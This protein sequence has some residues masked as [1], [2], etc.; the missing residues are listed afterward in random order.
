MSLEIGGRISPKTSKSP[1]LPMFV[2]LKNG[3]LI[4]LFL[5][6]LESST[7]DI[8][9]CANC[10]FNIGENLIEFYMPLILVVLLSYS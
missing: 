6:A 1:L 4:Y 2:S 8:L 10:A 7:L 3:G 5:T 9:I